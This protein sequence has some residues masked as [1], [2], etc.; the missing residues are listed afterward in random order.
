L[1]AEAASTTHTFFDHP[2]LIT[3]YYYFYNYYI[4]PIKTDIEKRKNRRKKAK[5]TRQL[6]PRPPT[7]AL[8]TLNLSIS[9][10]RR[11]VGEAEEKEE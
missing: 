3:N 2:I 4:T 11:K 1:S 10:R 9:T 8:T 6:W 7:T 5:V